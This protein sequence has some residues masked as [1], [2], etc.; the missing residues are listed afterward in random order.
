MSKRFKYGFWGSWL[1]EIVFI[2]LVL[3]L[4]VLI[5]TLL[6]G[7]S[8][9]PVNNTAVVEIQS[10]GGELSVDGIITTDT[11]FARERPDSVILRANRVSDVVVWVDSSP[12]PLPRGGSFNYLIYLPRK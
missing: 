4:V 1:G 8:E 7:C 3:I 9:P 12:L 10:Q 5:G 6:T 11:T 2:A